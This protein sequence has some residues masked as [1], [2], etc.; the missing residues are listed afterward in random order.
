MSRQL[1]VLVFLFM[2]FSTQAATISGLVMDEGEPVEFFVLQSSDGVVRAAFNACD[3]CFL[4]KKGYTRQGNEV[5]CN[6]CGRRFPAEL[7]NEV[8]GGCNPAPLSR[9]VDGDT[10]LILAEDI[11]EGSRY[12]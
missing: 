2:S 4:S 10:L 12:F 5:I 9:T 1:L 11:V 8:Q 3:V 7:I 6:N